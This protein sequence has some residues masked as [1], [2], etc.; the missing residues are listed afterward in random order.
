VFD[1]EWKCKIIVFVLILAFLVIPIVQAHYE[2]IDSTKN[3]SMR[4]YSRILYVNYAEGDQSNDRS[5]TIIDTAVYT[6][7][8]TIWFYPHMTDFL[9]IR[10]PG[11]YSCNTGQCPKYNDSQIRYFINAAHNKNISLF[12]AVNPIE[13]KSY[14]SIKKWLQDGNDTKYAAI[15]WNDSYIGGSGYK[16]LEP[17]YLVPLAKR[18]EM[19]KWIFQN[20]DFQGLYYEEP[21]IAQISYGPNY[22]CAQTRIGPFTKS[23]NPSD[24]QK[25]ALLKCREEAFTE[26]YKQIHDSIASIPD[27]KHKYPYF[28]IITGNMANEYKNGTLSGS[29]SM[30]YSTD[31]TNLYKKGYIDG[32]MFAG[33]APYSSNGSMQTALTNIKLSLAGAKT[34][35]AM[36]AIVNTA[37]Q[38]KTCPNLYDNINIVDNM[39]APYVIFHRSYLDTVAAFQGSSINNITRTCSGYSLGDTVPNLSISPRNWLNTHSPSQPRLFNPITGTVI[40]VIPA[41]TR[42][43]IQPASLSVEVGARINLTQNTRVYDQNDN[44]MSNVIPEWKSNNASVGTIDINGLFYA[45]AAGTTIITA[46]S[47]SVTGTVAVVVTI[48]QSIIIDNPGF[49]SGTES[50]TFYTDGSGTFGT[51]SP[52]F[53]GTKAANLS[54]NSSGTN[55][56]LYQ[57]G[58]TLEP[59]TSYRLSFAARSITGHDLTVRLFKHVSPYTNY[60]LNQ[61]FNLS[62]NWQTFTTKFN[63]TGFTGEVNDGRLQFWLSPFVRAGD[64]YY[65][66]EI[67]LEKVVIS[68]KLGD[69]NN[70]GIVDIN[71]LWILFGHFNESKLAPFPDYDMNADGNVDILDVVS[72]TNKI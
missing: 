65:L 15:D 12:L 6:K 41:V 24:E 50:W 59:N 28:T 8:D 71:D 56:Q 20:Y 11:E 60:G 47:G 62:S 64:I 2:T 1:T 54:M 22:E 7:S 51:V 29:N 35:T 40:P 69:L 61:T 53:N 4:P 19:Y 26:M 27:S 70:D 3:I 68:R 23:N 18:V 49:E 67:R 66:D 55:I 17:G 52:G 42:I 25:Y 48:Y 57:T 16:A 32:H 36:V 37:S 58:I 63:T 44:E 43:V 39:D 14:D 5:D 13:I 45:K 38:G 31:I 21:V 46:T 33:I 34:G 10:Y 30:I 72:V 9:A